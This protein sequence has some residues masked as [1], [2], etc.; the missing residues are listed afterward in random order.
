MS[1][2]RRAVRSA[3]LAAALA[4]VGLVAF[5]PATAVAATPTASAALAADVPFASKLD[6]NVVYYGSLQIDNGSSVT[7]IP[8]SSVNWTLNQ[9][10]WRVNFTTRYQVT[11]GTTYDISAWE[12]GQC[13]TYVQAWGRWTRALGGVTVTPSAADVSSGVYKV[14]IG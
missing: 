7:C 6:N 5:T 12:T 14:R 10:T 11:A 8:A 2:H 9:T 13:S 4:V 1:V 3:V